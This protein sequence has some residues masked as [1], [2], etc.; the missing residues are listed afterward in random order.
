[1]FQGAIKYL[2]NFLIHAEFSQLNS[3][4][5]DNVNLPPP[6]LAEESM[7]NGRKYLPLL[8]K[9]RSAIH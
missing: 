8:L 7:E 4:H 9:R 3:S 1:M 6:L 2:L 5:C